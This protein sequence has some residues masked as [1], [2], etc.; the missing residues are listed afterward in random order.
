M[1]RDDANASG[2][3]AWVHRIRASVTVRPGGAVHA[4]LGPPLEPFFHKE[5]LFGEQIFERLDPRRQRL[6]E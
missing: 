1:P 2:A 5:N 6:L 3:A 4:G